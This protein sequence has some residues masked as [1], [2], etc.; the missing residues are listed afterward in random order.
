ML[1]PKLNC[2]LEQH[3][4]PASFS[5]TVER[6]YINLAQ[7]IAL[8]FKQHP[9]HTPLIIGIQGC[10][11]SGKSTLASLLALILKENHRLDTLALSLDDFYLTRAQRAELAHEVHP[12]LATRGVPG[13]HDIALACQ[14]IQQ[15]SLLSANTLGSEK[16]YSLPRFNK[17]TDDRYPPSHWPRLCIQPHII[18]LEGWCIGL[19]AEEDHSLQHAVNEL[20]R[21]EDKNA[22]WRRH[23]NNALKNDYPGLFSL[24]DKLIVLQAPSFDCVYQWRW[25]QEEKL[26]AELDRQG[27]PNEQRNTMSPAQLTRFIS[28]YQR[29]TQHALATMPAKADWVLYL[30]EQHEIVK[31]HAAT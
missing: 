28:H 17:A 12:L 25:L 29:L 5:E 9:A 13:T 19:S 23:V 26:I 11:G 24:I 16:T 1:T 7:E 20:E 6:W 22:R 31:M 3:N 15:L 4:L 21:V 8:R 14:S 18:L 27:I 30:N 2:A 10:Q